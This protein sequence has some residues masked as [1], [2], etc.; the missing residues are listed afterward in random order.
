[1][2]AAIALALGAGVILI[3]THKESEPVYQGRPASYWLRRLRAP[4]LLPAAEGLELKPKGLKLNTGLEL[5][6]SLPS[7][8]ELPQRVVFSSNSSEAFR[9]MGSDAVPFLLRCLKEDDAVMSASAASML[10]AFAPID[11][12]NLGSLVEILRAKES[13]QHHLYRILSAV[14]PR[15]IRTRL[16]PVDVPQPFFNRFADPWYVR[17]YQAEMAMIE[18]LNRARNVQ[19]TNAH[20][21]EPFFETIPLLNGALEDREDKVMELAA[22]LLGNLGPDAK[23]AVPVLVKQLA[24]QR[25]AGFAREEAARAL[26]KIG[27]FDQKVAWALVI[28]GQSQDRPLQCAAISTLGRGGIACKDGIPMLT[29][30][31]K[32]GDPLLRCLAYESLRR[33]D[34]TKVAGLVPPGP[35][36][37]PQ[38][39]PGTTYTYANATDDYSL[40]MQ[41]RISD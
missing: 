7:F 38:T 23:R 13:R 34:A 17:G 2:V 16:P 24:N 33:I 31:L 36:Q 30:F 9:A 28:A 6:P 25:R 35:I 41:Y 29:N 12:D 22:A 5:K 32:S 4:D 20:A 40:Y 14:L 18:M 39:S 15:T 27:V 11:R 21:M 19:R 1:M 8:S 37:P 26:G 3:V 10:G